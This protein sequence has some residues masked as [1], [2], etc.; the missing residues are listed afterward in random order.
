MVR[1][2]ASE[3]Y[4]SRLQIANIGSGFHPFDRYKKLFLLGKRVSKMK[5]TASVHVVPWLRISCSIP[6]LPNMLSVLKQR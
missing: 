2:Y 5:L 4:D 3:S 6:P 1:F